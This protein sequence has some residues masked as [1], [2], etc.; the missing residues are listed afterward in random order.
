MVASIQSKVVDA[1]IQVQ[2]NNL[3]TGNS[4]V[5]EH[6]GNIDG[7]KAKEAGLHASIEL[8]D[9]RASDN[10]H[11]E[12]HNWLLYIYMNNSIFCKKLGSWKVQKITKFKAFWYFFRFSFSN[13]SSDK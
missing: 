1:R 9:Q 13:Y 4:V 6:E 10:I 12:M 8:T 11:A 2:S 5:C 3:L 7:I